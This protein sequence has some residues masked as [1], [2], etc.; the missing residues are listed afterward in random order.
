LST[1][2]CGHCGKKCLILEAI[3]CDLCM[4]WVHVSCEGLKRDHYKLLSQLAYSVPNITYYCKLH[5]CASRSKIN[6]GQWLLSDSTS[7]QTGISPPELDNLSSKVDDL[8]IHS[9]KLKRRSIKFVQSFKD[10]YTQTLDNAAQLFSVSASCAVDTVSAIKKFSNG[11]QCKCNIILYNVGRHK[12]F[13]TA[14][15]KWTWVK[16]WTSTSWNTCRK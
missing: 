10:I 4:S 3:Q 13:H 7:N 6:V 2:I 14:L 15:Q 8:T 9:T 1:D 16:Y 11:E 12:S 5:N